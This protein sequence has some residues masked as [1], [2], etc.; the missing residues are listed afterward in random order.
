MREV[1]PSQRDA[2][3]AALREVGAPPAVASALAATA[4][5]EMYGDVT[6]L[7]L[8]G[9]CSEVEGPEDLSAVQELADNAAADNAEAFDRQG[10]GEPGHVPWWPLPHR[11]ARG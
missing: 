9:N 10:R 1:S 5:L 11:Q 4:T 7:C 8:E 6:M 3:D 2:L